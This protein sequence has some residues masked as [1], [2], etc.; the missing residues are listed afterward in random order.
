MGD[1]LL[2]EYFIP[3]LPPKVNT[4][5]FS[6]CLCLSLQ[7]LNQM[8]EEQPTSKHS[9]SLKLDTLAV[10]SQFER[11]ALMLYCS[12]LSFPHFIPFVCSFPHL[13]V[14]KIIKRLVQA[15][16]TDCNAPFH[17]ILIS[18]KFSHFLRAFLRRK[19]V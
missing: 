16:S 3:S 19:P 8:K 11:C 5:Q 13:F 9:F 7:V 17:L 4:D 12:V 15:M 14:Y 10:H 6:P 1:V 18:G 2:Y